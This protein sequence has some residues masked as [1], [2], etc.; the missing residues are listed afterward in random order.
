MAAAPKLGEGR[1]D[2]YCLRQNGSLLHM[3]L[4]VSWPHLCW[5]SWA[6]PEQDEAGLAQDMGPQQEL[7]VAQSCPLQET[8]LATIATPA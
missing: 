1:S 2:P 5:V 4:A 3:A 8:M 6:S 7:A